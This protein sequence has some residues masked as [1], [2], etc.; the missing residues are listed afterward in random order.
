V[1][2]T[3]SWLPAAEQELADIWLADQDRAAVSQAAA[4]LDRQL[5]NDRT[6]LGKRGPMAAG[7]ISQRRWEFSSGFMATICGLWLLTFG[8]TEASSLDRAGYGLHWWWQKS[9]SGRS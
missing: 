7:S 3:G 8:P 2:H 4:L 9:P 6:H 1:K 5:A